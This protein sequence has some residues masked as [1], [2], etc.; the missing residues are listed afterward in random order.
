MMNR[1]TGRGNV[2]ESAMQTATDYA[3]L[4]IL[5]LALTALPAYLYFT[6]NVRE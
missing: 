5:P 2:I 3:P 6:R 1:V 4:G